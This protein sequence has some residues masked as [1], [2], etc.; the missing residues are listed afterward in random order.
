[1]CTKKNALRFMYLSCCKYCI[2]ILH[3]LCTYNIAS[4][5]AS[6]YRFS[7]VCDWCIPASSST[8]HE[9]WDNCVSNV[10]WTMYLFFFGIHSLARSISLSFFYNRIDKRDEKKKIHTI[11]LHSNSNSICMT[12]LTINTETDR[13][14]NQ[15]T[16]TFHCI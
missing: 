15:T 13:N 7:C 12:Q 2:Y 4:E 16:E 9:K 5:R 8:N 6:L 14:K 11:Y 3:H 10:L 1:M